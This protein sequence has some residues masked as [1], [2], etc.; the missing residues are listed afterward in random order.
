MDKELLDRAAAKP[1]PKVT[2]ADIE[3]SIKAEYGYNGAEMAQQ[4]GQPVVDEL[5]LLT[6][7]VLV[8][9]NGFT[10][11]G[12]S[13]CA[14]PDNYERDLG[15]KIARADAISQCWPLLGYA[16]KDK[17]AAAAA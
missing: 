11:V 17:L 2:Q 10:V 4:A 6:I 13:A 16:L 1:A 5:K 14:S 8:L 7:Y 12:K 3:A 15:M 9:K